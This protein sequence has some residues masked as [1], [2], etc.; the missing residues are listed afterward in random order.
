MEIK[1]R[2]IQYGEMNHA[3]DGDYFMVDEYGIKNDQIY[4]RTIMIGNDEYEVFQEY[5]DDEML[6]S[7]F[8][9]EHHIPAEWKPYEVDIPTRDHVKMDAENASR[10]FENIDLKDI[11]GHDGVLDEPTLNKVYQKI[12]DKLVT[13]ETLINDPLV[14]DVFNEALRENP[15]MARWESVFPFFR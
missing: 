8:L 10:L 15:E 7:T 11:Q 5:P 3:F 2:V 4:H 1:D 9:N 13:N 6:L 12:Y 14:I